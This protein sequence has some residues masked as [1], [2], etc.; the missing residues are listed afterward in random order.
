MK[1]QK[2][3][4]ILAGILA[5]S[6]TAG[7]VSAQDPVL[8]RNAVGYVKVEMESAVG[9]PRYYLVANPFDS[10]DGEIPLL[11]EV[12][13]AVPNN[14]VIA[15]WDDQNQVYVNY[16][17]SGRGA[18]L[19]DAA[20]ARIGRAEGAFISVPSGA[21]PFEVVFMGEV[22]A[23]DEPITR[24]QGYSLIGYA[25]PVTQRLT[26]TVMATELPNNSIITVW[27][28]ETQVYINYTKSGRGAWLGDASTAEFNP[29]EGFFVF[30]G[31]PSQI[32]EETKPYT[33]P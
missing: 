31:N 33:W 9:Q 28:P 25:F 29:G 22:P 12:F 2:M 6:M 20:T 18:W 27:D 23:E 1:E 11:S 19:G 10:L 24:A 4:K 3:N 26:N 15:V 32:W 5:V 30:S 14:T 17:K 16:T 7:L 13:S 8:S 21:A